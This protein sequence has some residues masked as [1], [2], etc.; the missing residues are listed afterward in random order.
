MEPEALLAA[1][2][3]LVQQPS[4]ATAGLWPRAAALLARRALEEGLC[5]FWRQRVPALADIQ[6]MRCQ[7]VCLTALDGRSFGDRIHQTWL[8]LSHACHYHP[9]ELAPT[10]DELQG[11][12]ES[13]AVLL[14]KSRS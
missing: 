9:Y 13:V 14:G 2:R 4:P 7:L 1:A 6:N 11:W 10:A 8:A 12:M 3:D 5:R